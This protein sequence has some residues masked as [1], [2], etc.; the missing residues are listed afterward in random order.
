MARLIGPNIIQNLAEFGHSVAIDGGMVLV[1]APGAGP[2]THGA[3]YLYAR[4]EGGA[5]NWGLAASFY[6]DIYDTNAS[7]GTGVAID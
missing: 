7:M 5:G 2:S 4:D 6:D 3:A 1:G